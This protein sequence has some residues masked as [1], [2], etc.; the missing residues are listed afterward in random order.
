[1]LW[2][3][4]NIEQGEGLMSAVVVGSRLLYQMSRRGLM[5]RVRDEQRH[6]GGRHLA[7]WMQEKSD[8][9]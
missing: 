6:K 4:R 3:N 9:G 7:E 5:E 2:K 8:R 1:M